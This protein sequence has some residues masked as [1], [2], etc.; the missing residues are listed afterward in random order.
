ME[1]K[2]ANLFSGVNQILFDKAFNG[3]INNTP[4]N[5][6][7]LLARLKE[8]DECGQPLAIVAGPSNWHI[9]PDK[10]LTKPES[11]SEG[12]SKDPCIGANLPQGALK[13]KWGAKSRT[14]CRICKGTDHDMRECSVEIETEME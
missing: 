8:F 12:Q 13:R 14:F 7:E 1:Y 10:D 3:F 4:K 11:I 6:E 5:P 2:L 9:E